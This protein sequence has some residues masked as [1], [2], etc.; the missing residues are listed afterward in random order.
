MK[1]SLLSMLR[2]SQPFN[3]GRMMNQIAHNCVTFH[4]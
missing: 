3:Q 2:K 1:G 4:K